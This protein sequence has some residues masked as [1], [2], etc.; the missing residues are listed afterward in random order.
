MSMANLIDFNSKDIISDEPG[1]QRAPGTG[2]IG[3]WLV[4]VAATLWRVADMLER[5]SP[6]APKR[7]RRGQPRSGSGEHP[8]TKHPDPDVRL[9]VDLADKVMEVATALSP[10]DVQAELESD[11]DIPF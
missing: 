8:L 3:Q 5:T 4:H 11:L 1:P 10:P 9:L 7:R 2:L 6:H